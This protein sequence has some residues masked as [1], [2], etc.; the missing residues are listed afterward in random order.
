DRPDR[1]PAHA[2]PVVARRSS[3][4]ARILRRARS[5]CTATAQCAAQ[6]DAR[7]EMAA[8]ESTTPAG[9][10]DPEGEHERVAQVLSSELERI[11]SPEAADAVVAEVEALAAGT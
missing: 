1:R 7:G 11:D 3:A 2:A 10:H 4:L 6:P 9:G 5:E 8:P